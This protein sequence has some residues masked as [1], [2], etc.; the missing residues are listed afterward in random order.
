MTVK[1]FAHLFD[2]YVVFLIRNDN[3]SLEKIS[4]LH[5]NE[6]KYKDCT[7]KSVRHRSTFIYIILDEKENKNDQ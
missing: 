5:I 2:E 3:K 4:N 1:E 7:I 6:S